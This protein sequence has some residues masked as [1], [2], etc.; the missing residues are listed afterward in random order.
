MFEELIG[1][2]D[3]TLEDSLTE[4]DRMNVERQNIGRMNLE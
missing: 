1:E 2:W 3:M 4:Y